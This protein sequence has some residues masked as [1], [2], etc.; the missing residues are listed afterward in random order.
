MENKS[1]NQAVILAGGLG[2]RMRP[3]T[4]TAPK[5]MYP[6][7]GKPFIEYLIK[8]VKSF[9]IDNILILLGYLPE[10]IMDYLGNG[11]AYDVNIAYDI[12]PVE[13]NTGDR[14]LHANELIDE[15]FLLMYCDN[16]CPIDFLKLSRD[17]EDNQALIQLTAYEN[18]DGY[19]K[20]NLLLEENGLVKA[21]D[22]KRTTP[23]L[24]GVDIGYAIINKKVF[25]FLTGQDINFEAAVYPEMVR[26]GKMFAT[27]TK[28][29]YYSVGSWERIK[30]TEQFFD[31]QPTVFLDRDGTI[32]ERPPKAC[33]VESP[34]QFI[35]LEGAKEA[36]R[37]LKDSG[38]RI[39]LVSN[40]PGIARGNLTEEMLGKIHEKMQNELK[41]ET[42]CQ[43]DAIYYCPHNWEE[44][45]ECRKPKPGMLY[46]AQKDFSLNLTEC[47]LFGDD[48]RDIQAGNAAGCRSIL[49][50]EE[51]DLAEA[52]RD[53]LKA[54]LA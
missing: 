13:Y 25:K 42:G 5:P 18:K 24:Q 49:I 44:G 36:I 21:Y 30:L 31:N 2:T 28:H 14:L 37:L 51:Y 46:Q 15:H 19:T 10:K 39:V 33:Y 12:T 27:V 54:K 8:Q 3:F 6:F 9:G 22:K 23:G 40:Q 48:E 52:V 29:R 35:W 16:Y 11:S 45:C 17:Y 41:E 7:N 47:Y 32:N 34:E 50:N 38:Y 26:Q 1:V 43:I 53:L 4:D 20:N